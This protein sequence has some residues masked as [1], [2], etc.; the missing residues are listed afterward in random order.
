MKKFTH[1]IYIHTAYHDVKVLAYL[2]KTT[3]VTDY[4]GGAK[5]YLTKPKGL[6]MKTVG[7]GFIKD[8]K[9]TLGYALPPYLPGIALLDTLKTI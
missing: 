4:L 8:K 9:H 1:T 7:F 5:Y 6:T 2:T 3:V